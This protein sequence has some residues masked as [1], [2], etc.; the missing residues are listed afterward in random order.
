MLDLIT[1][2]YLNRR[3]F[4]E[5][6]DGNC[7]LSR[8]YAARLAET[9]PTWG[10]AVAP[11]AEW[12]A[13][14]F[15]KTIRR[16]DIPLATRLTQNNK[17]AAKGSLRQSVFTRVPAHQNLC[18]E[19]GTPIARNVKHC[20]SCSLKHSTAALIQGAQLGRKISHEARAQERRKETRHRH[21]LELHNWKSANQPSWL[22]EQVYTTQIQPRL[23][24]ATL[25]QIA[26]EI[27]VSIP[28]AS[29]VR[30]G[31]RRPHPRHWQKLAKLVSVSE[32]ATESLVTCNH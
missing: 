29:D 23:K 16:P 6:P 13:R 22:T 24:T 2:E 10:R 3:W 31:K 18:A 17:R 7:R 5:Q 25:S 19:C 8:E 32:A 21:A 30:K 12:V 26:S 9:A 4:V 14:E 11:V 15:W 28:Y 27:G 1:R 20:A